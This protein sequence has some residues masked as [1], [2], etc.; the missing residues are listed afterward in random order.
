M[1][2]TNVQFEDGNKTNLGFYSNSIFIPNVGTR[3][4]YQQEALET[5]EQGDVFWIQDSIDVDN[6]DEVIAKY[7]ASGNTYAVRNLTI[8]KEQRERVYE[9]VNAI[10][11]NVY[12]EAMKGRFDFL[13]PGYIGVP[14]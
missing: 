3:I 6:I 11:G 2:T 1:F 8:M 13:S 14:R 5:L 9:I 7:Q 12:S 10:M 4:A